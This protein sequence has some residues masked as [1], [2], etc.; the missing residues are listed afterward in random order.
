[1]NCPFCDKENMREL[2]LFESKFTVVA[3]NP[4]PA[5]KAHLL[6]VSKEHVGSI[7]EL[8]DEQCSDLFILAKKVASIIKEHLCP[9]GMNIFFNEGPIA[10]Q[11][12]EHVHLHVIPRNN[13]DG[14][15]NFKRKAGERQLL[16]EDDREM[17]KR[18]F[19]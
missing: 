12:I 7:T 16:R 5:T 13:G 15:K 11:T 2:V 19:A 9:E 1:M 4:F 14:L 18:I 17:L 6:V 3:M 10:G 8:S